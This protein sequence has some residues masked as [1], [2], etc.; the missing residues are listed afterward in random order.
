MSRT[1]GLSNK[2]IAEELNISE[3]AVEKH[4]TAALKVIKSHFGRFF[5]L[6]LLLKGII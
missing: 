1:G 6:L 4:I 3:K 5:Y 2:E